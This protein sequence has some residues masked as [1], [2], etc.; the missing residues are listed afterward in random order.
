MDWFTLSIGSLPL[1]KGGTYLSRQSADKSSYIG[2]ALS[3]QE[4]MQQHKR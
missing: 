2:S 4:R 1:N 3:F